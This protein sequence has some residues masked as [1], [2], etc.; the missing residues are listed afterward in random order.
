MFI[1][2]AVP[3][4]VVLGY[5]IGGRLDRLGTMRFEW[6]WLAIVGLVVQVLL[7][8]PLLTAVAD[9]E[10]GAAVYVVSTAAVLVAV[11]RNISVPGMPLVWLGA[12]SNLAAVIANGGIM[13]TT[14]A[15]L[16]TAG[17]EPVTGLS[18]SAVVANPALGPLT[19]I[20]A[21][22]AWFP[23]ANVFSIGDVLIGV[24]IVIVIVF[25]MRSRHPRLS[26]A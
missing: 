12:A 5:L 4:G 13:P 9:A 11:L 1:L 15:A 23:L 6:A 26:R 24:G 14:D 22:P 2:Y 19:D 21:L 25:G 17:L 8:S 3:I 20:F 7:F 16:T 18:N 10:V